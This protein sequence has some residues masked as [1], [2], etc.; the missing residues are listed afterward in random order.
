MQIGIDFVPV[1]VSTVNL[2]IRLL[3]MQTEFESNQREIC[4]IAIEYGEKC[5]CLFTLVV[6]TYKTVN[7]ARVDWTIIFCVNRKWFGIGNGVF[8]DMVGTNGRKSKWLRIEK[9][10]LLRS[11]TNLFFPLT[12][13]ESVNART[14]RRTKCLIRS[15]RP[16]SDHS[17]QNENDKTEIVVTCG[18]NR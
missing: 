13:T 2:S 7:V 18:T 4:P 14:R 10:R 11:N 3:R 6:R 12:K 1:P 16:R 8:A 17:A 9:N 5:V 15:L